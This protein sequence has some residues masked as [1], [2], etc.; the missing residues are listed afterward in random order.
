MTELDRGKEMVD[1]IDVH[2]GLLRS[3]VQN[4]HEL[5]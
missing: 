3:G 4:L 2:A 1:M 5:S